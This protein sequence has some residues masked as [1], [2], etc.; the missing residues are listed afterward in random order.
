VVTVNPARLSAAALHSSATDTAV[1]VL[2]IRPASPS[3]LGITE[4]RLVAYRTDSGAVALLV[5][6]PTA[7][8]WR[9]VV[10]APY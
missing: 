4:A 8:L 5:A 2:T 1:A 9:E 10:G 7:N 3:S 6:D